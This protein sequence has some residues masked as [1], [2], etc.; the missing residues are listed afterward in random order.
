MDQQRTGGRRSILSWFRQPLAFRARELIFIGD[1]QLIKKAFHNLVAPYYPTQFPQ[2]LCNIR[3]HA[4][5][6]ATFAIGFLEETEGIAGFLNALESHKR[7]WAQRNAKPHFVVLCDIAKDNN[8]VPRKLVEDLSAYGNSVLW[9]T[10]NWNDEV[11]QIHSPRLPDN[12]QE[13]GPF[14]QLVKDQKNTTV[15]Q[16]NTQDIS[17]LSVDQGPGEYT[18]RDNFHN[19]DE[20]GPAAV[21]PHPH[22][23]ESTS[24]PSSTQVLSGSGAAESPTHGVPSEDRTPVVSCSEA[25]TGENLNNSPSKE[26]MTTVNQGTLS[27]KSSSVLPSKTAYKIRELKLRNDILKPSLKAG[28]RY[29]RW[30]DDTSL[31]T[32]LEELVQKKDADLHHTIT[33]KAPALQIGTKASAT[34]VKDSFELSEDDI[35]I[36]VMGPTGAGKSTFIKNATGYDLKIGNELE[37]CTSEIHVIRF[38]VDDSP[39]YIVDTPGFND[40]HRSDVEIFTRISEWL[41]QRFTNQVYLSGLV[42]LHRISDNRMS[43][44]TLKNLQIFEQICGKDC[45]DKITLATTMWDDVEP[46]IGDHREK[47]LKHDYFSYMIHRGARLARLGNDTNS[48][49]NIILRIADD[50]NT[51]NPLSLQKELVA[52]QKNLPE[53]KAGRQ[54]YEK[55]DEV[56]QSHQLALQQLSRDLRAET[57]ESVRAVLRK[58]H[59]ALTRELVDLIADIQYMQGG[60]PA[61]LLRVFGS[62]IGRK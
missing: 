13:V 27:P 58:E 2:F 41:Q 25:T 5:I 45:F 7:T 12:A 56:L 42:Y 37:S 48:A 51:L 40:T 3:I 30:T 16:L 21:S 34:E 19:E 15:S 24:N 59:E 10:G 18:D 38:F 28:G 4:D 11:Q 53:T 43:G 6:H 36:A 39:I 52:F 46:D 50:A 17:L 14:A 47:Q 35:I 49:R 31:K 57:S 1:E 33:K 22:E 61:R 54:V 60:V 9:L 32:A 20:P 62:L 29:V 26:P 23:V 8:D 44:T 55:L